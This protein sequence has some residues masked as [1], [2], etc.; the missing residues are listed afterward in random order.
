MTSPTALPSHI[1]GGWLGTLHLPR[2]TGHRVSSRRGHGPLELQ[3]ARR[4][5]PGADPVHRTGAAD[6][7]EDGE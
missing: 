7:E 5:E 3:D 6:H 2:S 4:A 1:D